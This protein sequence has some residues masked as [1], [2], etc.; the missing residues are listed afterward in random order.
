M[1]WHLS[2]LPCRLVV[3][4]SSVPETRK[5]W[6]WEVE[7]ITR[8]L[9]WCLLSSFVRYLNCGSME[10]WACTWLFVKYQPSLH[11]DHQTTMAFADYELQYERYVPI[12][13]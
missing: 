11:T 3:T 8:A 6:L 7:W 2:R 12:P 5:R 10:C 13:G 4:K 9:S 1:S